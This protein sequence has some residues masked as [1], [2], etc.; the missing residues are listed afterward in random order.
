MDDVCL[1]Y[2]GSGEE[3]AGFN[4]TFPEFILIRKQ[5]FN[6]NLFIVSKIHASIT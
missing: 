5:I 1:F 4:E 3:I 6:P 2:T